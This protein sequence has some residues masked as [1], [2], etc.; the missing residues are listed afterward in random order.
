MNLGKLAS[1]FLGAT[2]SAVSWCA[3]S[4][5]LVMLEQPG[6]VWCARFDAEIAQNEAD[7]KNAGHWGVPLFV[8][9]DE[10]FFGQDRLE[11][12]IWRMRQHGLVER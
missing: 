4:A 10:P 3:W 5:E 12:V 11:H 7:Q 2:L 6:C 8:F 9:N 1:L